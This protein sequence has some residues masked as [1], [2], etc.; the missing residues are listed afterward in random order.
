[1]S[2]SFDAVLFDMDGT[3]VETES[4]WFASEQEVVA[5]LGGEWTPSHQELFVGGPLDRMITHM[6]ALTSSAASDEQVHDDLVR[7]MVRRLGAGPIHWMPGARE[8]LDDLNAAGVPTALVSASLRVMVDAVLGHVGSEH[9][10]AT[11]AGDD[12]A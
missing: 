6:I 1:M 8:L 11:V 4:I 7:A 10:G 2:A 5:G 9:F 3:L 12:V